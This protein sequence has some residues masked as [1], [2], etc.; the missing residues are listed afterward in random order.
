MGAASDM[1]QPSLDLKAE[2]HEAW[3]PKWPWVAAV[4][5][6]FKTNPLHPTTHVD[7]FVDAFYSTRKTSGAHL[8]LQCCHAVT[9]IPPT[10]TFNCPK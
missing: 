5:P 1:S 6:I 7:A 10:T 2:H 3:P 4:S 8:I 9:C